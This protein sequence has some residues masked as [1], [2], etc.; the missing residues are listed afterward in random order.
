LC[1]DY[2]IPVGSIADTGYVIPSLIIQDKSLYDTILQALT[3]TKNQTGRRFFIS[4]SAGK[5][6]LQPLASTSSKYVIEV[7]TNLTDASYSKSIEDTVTQ[8][9]VL[10]GKNDVYVVKK[11]DA[12]LAAKYGI[13]QAIET[14]DEKATKA[15]VEQRASALLKEKAVINDQASV[16]ALG[17]DDVITGVKVTVHEPMTGLS[18]SYYVS[19]DTHTYENGNHTMSL[20]LSYT[21]DLPT[22]GA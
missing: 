16:D 11:K 6:Y 18:G 7:G 4:S 15:Q 17:V 20:E 3:L 5:F 2:G 9:K 13:M 14:M 19:S 8:V 1:S 22:E 10:G 21:Y 12:T